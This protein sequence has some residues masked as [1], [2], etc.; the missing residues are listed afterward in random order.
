MLTHAHAKG[1]RPFFSPPLRP[2]YEAKGDL[3]VA[4]YIML[5][6]PEKMGGGGSG[7]WVGEGGEE[8]RTNTAFDSIVNITPKPEDRDSRRL[9]SA[10]KSSYIS[11]TD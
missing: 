7:K 8:T 2:E 9:T 4:V 5:R 6:K 10:H 11:A 1:T 3:L